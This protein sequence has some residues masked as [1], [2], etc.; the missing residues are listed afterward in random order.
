MIL[1]RLLLVALA[2]SAVVPA[3]C[4]K[5]QKKES[6]L[7]ADLGTRRNC[8]PRSRRCPPPAGSRPRPA[9][10]T[11]APRV[12]P[13]DQPG[14][15]H[16]GD[17]RHRLATAPARIDSRFTA[18][19]A[20]VAELEAQLAATADPDERKG[21]LA[22]RANAGKRSWRR[23]RKTSRCCRRPPSA[24]PP[25]P[26]PVP[27]KATPLPKADHR[28]R[29]RPRPKS[30]APSPAKGDLKAVREVLDAA[31]K[32]NDATASFEAYLVKREAIKGKEQPARRRS[33]AS[34]RSR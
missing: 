29:P 7:L 5:S 9:G 17:A 18:Q 25:L 22:R 24:R 30:R 2:G 31:K 12:R 16:A 19:Q 1:R 20:T 8:P 13:E 4:L 23:K 34:V 6:S 33:T 15:R 10:C 14:A 21:I 11:T 3:A 27:P 28:S 32:K 26:V